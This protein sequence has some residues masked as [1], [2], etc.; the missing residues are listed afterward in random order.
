MERRLCKIQ[1]AIP[2]AHRLRERERERGA[3]G[4]W[5]GTPGSTGSRKKPFSFQSAVYRAIGVR[6][7]LD[8]QKKCNG[9]Q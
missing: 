2:E 6:R 4:R 3:R 1:P 9:T 7:F 5:R 8:R